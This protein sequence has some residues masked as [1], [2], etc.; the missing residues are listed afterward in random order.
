MNAVYGDLKRSVFFWDEETPDSTGGHDARPRVT[1][2]MDR[3]FNDLTPFILYDFVVELYQE[4]G[5]T[6]SISK[7]KDACIIMDVRLDKY[8]DYLGRDFR[9]MMLTSPEY[10]NIFSRYGV[11]AIYL[12][13]FPAAD[14]NL[15]CHR[16]S[17]GRA[18]RPVPSST[19]SL[20]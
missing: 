3:K 10:H 9:Y 7:I 13:N 5:T 17:V 11:D 20:T 12:H 19:P 18:G 4:F 2:H 15:D 14:G 1:F 8:T 6:F 16:F